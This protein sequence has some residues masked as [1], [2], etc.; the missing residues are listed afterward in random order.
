MGRKKALSRRKFLRGAGNV[1]IALPFLDAMIPTFAY[2]QSNPQ[3]RFVNLYYG[4]TNGGYINPSNL[5]PLTAPLGISIK[6]LEAIKQ[7]ISIV[8]RI[9]LPQVNRN[10]LPGPGEASQAQH[11]KVEGPMLSGMRSLP[12][13]MF[14]QHQNGSAFIRGTTADQVAAQ[15][16]GSGSKFNSLQMRV[17]A[18]DYNGKNYAPN[19]ISVVKKG[20][21]LNPM[22]PIISPLEVYEKLYS[23]GLPGNNQPPVSSLPLKKKS[24]L[25][26]V[27]EDA[28]RLI[29]SV[30]G[31]DK[32]RLEQHFENIREIERSL[33][34]TN[35]PTP[36]STGNCSLPNKPGV[37]P[38]ISTYSF[39]GWAN[40]TQR[41]QQQAEMIVQALN[42][43]LTHVV[44]WAI[45][46][47]QVWINSKQTGNSPFTNSASGL[48]DIHADSHTQ[49][50]RAI[51]AASHDWAVNFFGILVKRLS[52]MNDA[53]G[54]LLDH[55]FLTFMTAEDQNAHGRSN[56]S[57]L[58]AGCPDQ[59]KNGEH[60]DGKNAHPATA[61][62]TGLRA[63][64]MN[65]NQLGEVSGVIPGLLK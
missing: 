62:I 19:A 22:R 52:E 6:S 18:A 32:E 15:F 44:S 64:G 9:N 3:F 30:G 13:S 58:V 60:I 11:G 5:G 29:K 63:I 45:T 4:S 25:D 55:T 1:A 50:A 40:E 57:Y 38:K 51:N 14:N 24:V 34:T 7:H 39:G 12:N 41:G 21:I 48:P 53:H 35:A 54:S 61:L 37:D 56:F 10:Q 28:N 2:G 42:C 65:T 59:M 8:S 46:H 27:L 16:L 26:L 17:Q 43:G 49:G 31:Q 36:N 20:S 23:G 33:G 47:H